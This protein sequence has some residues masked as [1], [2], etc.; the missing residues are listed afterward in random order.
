MNNFPQKQLL[1]NYLLGICT[2]KERSEVDR[3]LEED[4]KN[5]TFLLQVANE[6]GNSEHF[7]LP[8]KAQVKKELMQQ[9]S[10]SLPFA[11]KTTGK[12][13]SSRHIRRPLFYNRR[14]FWLKI[15]A[16]FL[17]IIMASVTGIF[18]GMNFEQGQTA[19]VQPEIIFQQS[20]LSYGQT[21]SLRFGDGSIININGGSS[22]RYPETFAPDR[23]EVWLEGEAFFSIAHDETR[24][25]I[26]HAGKITTRVLGTSFNI[27]AY[28]GEGELQI[29]VADGRVEVSTTDADEFKNNSREVILLEKNQW[30]TY[31]GQSDSGD[32]VLEKGVGDIRDMIAWKDRMLVFRNKP[33]D[34]VAVMLER[35]YGVNITIED[36]SLKSYI[37][38]GEHHNASLEEVLNS[39]QFVMDFDYIIKGNEIFIRNR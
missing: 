7:P 24:P 35:W 31:R 38:E 15:A 2:I 29:A 6:I 3:W 1:I 21:A 4:Q 11:R 26:V 18:F 8:D 13:Q 10:K 33:F 17:V 30:I 5:V 14:E 36:P 19:E 37:L 32:L 27:K 34:Q 12:V 20:T 9:I 22:L 23:R 16:M 39:I 25:F 28:E